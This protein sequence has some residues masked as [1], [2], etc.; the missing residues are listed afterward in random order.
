M[1]DG[2]KGP[3]TATDPYAGADA[4]VVAAATKLSLR[5]IADGQVDQNVPE[6]RALR[7]A[8]ERRDTLDAGRADVITAARRVVEITDSEG[9]INIDRPEFNTGLRAVLIAQGELDEV[10]AADEAPK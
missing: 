10:P 6:V 3:R 4:D 5:L 1:A 9:F 2:K 7:T 8:I